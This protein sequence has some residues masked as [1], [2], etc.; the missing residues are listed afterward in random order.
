MTTK[1]PAPKKPVPS[2][3]A[4]GSKIPEKDMVDTLRK[5]AGANA[6]KMLANPPAY[7]KGG[8]VKKTGMALVHKGEVVTPA[9]KGRQH[10]GGRCSSK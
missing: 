7:K 6:K 2:L 5:A 10:R 3:T 8:K 1:K 4:K 9:G